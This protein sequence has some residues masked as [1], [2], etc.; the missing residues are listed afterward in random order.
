[1]EK[2]FFKIQNI[3]HHCLIFF[4]FLVKLLLASLYIFHCCRLFVCLSVCFH[5]ITHQIHPHLL[6]NI[7]E[8][9]FF[10]FEFFELNWKIF[11]LF[12]FL[13]FLPNCL[14][15]FTK[16]VLTCLHTQTHSRVYQYLLSQNFFF[17]IKSLYL[18]I[19]MQ[20][21]TLV[22]GYNNYWLLIIYYLYVYIYYWLLLMMI[23]FDVLLL[24]IIYWLF[25]LLLLLLLIF[26]KLMNDQNVQIITVW[27]IMK[28]EFLSKK[29]TFLK[30]FRKI[31]V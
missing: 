12:F 22:R 13:F 21:K 23:I 19:I 27:M 29:S 4:F 16:F 24:Y 9:F 5:S 15:R 8:T 28:N 26:K 20:K 6:A 10:F 11:M 31:L 25:K 17:S 14:S 30:D 1:M 7:P 18:R 2:K 3:R